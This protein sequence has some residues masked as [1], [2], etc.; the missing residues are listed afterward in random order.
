MKGGEKYDS[1]KGL[2]VYAQTFSF[3]SLQWLPE[4]GIYIVLTE[5][6]N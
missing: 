2:P 3:E 5:E 6:N 1:V 4:E